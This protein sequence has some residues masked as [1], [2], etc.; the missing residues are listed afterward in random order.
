MMVIC[1]SKRLES[2]TKPAE[3][4]STGR[5]VS[6]TQYRTHAPELGHTAK[7]KLRRHPCKSYVGITE[8]P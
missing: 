2:S 4:P 3:K 5:L 6:S 8:L 1:H 7:Q